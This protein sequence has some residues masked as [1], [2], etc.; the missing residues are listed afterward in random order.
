MNNKE[1]LDHMKSS[2]EYLL[3]EMRLEHQETRDTLKGHEVRISSLERWRHKIHGIAITLTAI[4]T[5]IKSGGS[6]HRG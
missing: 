4:I 3:A 2:Q 5:W 6:L 1:L